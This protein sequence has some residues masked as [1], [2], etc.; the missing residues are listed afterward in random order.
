MAGAV[1]GNGG[2]VPPPQIKQVYTRALAAGH[3]TIRGDEGWDASSLA[4]F[5]A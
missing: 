1:N 5:F 2:V 4:T 3:V